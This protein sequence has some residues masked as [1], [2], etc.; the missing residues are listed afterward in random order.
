[1]YVFF[2]TTKKKSNWSAH[3]LMSNLVRISL[4]VPP[5]YFTIKKCSSNL[6]KLAWFRRSGHWVHTS[7]VTGLG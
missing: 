6:H 5:K 2:A 4:P 7:A 1:L 3:P